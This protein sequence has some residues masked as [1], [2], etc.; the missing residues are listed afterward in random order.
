[1][2]ILVSDFCISSNSKVIVIT[3]GVRQVKGESRLD[4]V[5]RNTEVLKNII[6]T[7]V[8]YSPN[9]VIIVVTNPG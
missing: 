8:S 6:P 9:A 4:T 3:A 2:E 7:L 5:G 1:M